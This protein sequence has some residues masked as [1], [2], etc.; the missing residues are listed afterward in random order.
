MMQLIRGLSHL[1]PFKQGCVLTI[2]NFDGVHTGH[3]KVIEKLAQQGQQQGLPVVVMVFEP[4]PLEF[5][6]GDNAPTRLMSLR[7]KVQQFH[8]LPIDYLLVV[9]FNKQFANYH[10]DEFVHQLLVKQLN[11][12]HL[13][14]GDDFHFG[15]ARCGNF[16]MLRQQG[17]LLGFNVEDTYSFYNQ[18]HRVSSTLIRDTLR[19]D[20]LSTAKTLLGRHYSICGRVVYGHQQGRTIGFPTANIQL[21]RHNRPISGV[22]AVTVTGINNQEYRGIA[23]IGTRPTL[24]NGDNIVLE[25]HLFDVNQ[26]IYGQFIEVHFKQKIRA[27]IQFDSFQQLKQQI[28]KDCLTVK[29]F[30]YSDEP[31]SYKN[32]ISSIKALT[33]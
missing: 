25:T 24:N 2:G 21:A 29:Q 12:K 22:F 23:N 11:V 5:F 9:K 4:Q 3:V 13:V 31:S 16:T 15:K 8:L 28:K 19:N 6:L 27:E 32:G 17:Q 20:D 33:E 7:E 14:V 26:S 18:G 10:A 1:K 30:F